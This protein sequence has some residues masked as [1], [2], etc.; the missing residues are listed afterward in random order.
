VSRRRRSNVVRVK[1]SNSNVMFTAMPKDLLAFTPDPGAWPDS[2]GTVTTAPS[3]C[4]DGAECHPQHV[5]M[6][7]STRHRHINR[8][9]VTHVTQPRA[10]STMLVATSGGSDESPEFPQSFEPGCSCHV[11][12]YYLQGQV[13]PIFS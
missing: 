5:E 2:P 4:L 13:V 6:N 10:A 3:R 11:S 7:L 9:R 8:H 12:W 1:R